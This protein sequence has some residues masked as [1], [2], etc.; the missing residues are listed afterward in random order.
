VNDLFGVEMGMSADAS[1]LVVGA[2]GYDNNVGAFW[3]F[4]RNATGY[5]EEVQS[6]IQPATTDASPFIASSVAMS[7]DGSTVAIGILDEE[8]T[9]VVGHGAVAMYTRDSG[10]GQWSLLQPLLFGDTYDVQTRNVGKS[11]GISISGDVVVSAGGNLVVADGSKIMT[12]IRGSDGLFTNVGVDVEHPPSEA[13]AY[14]A[15]VLSCDAR[16][17]FVTASDGGYFYTRAQGDTTVWTLRT[18]TPI[19]STLQGTTTHTSAMACDGRITAT[20][21]NTDSYANIIAD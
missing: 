20:Q 21:S 4:E 14:D 6:T 7:A 5:Y 16:T 13:T 1:I 17:L 12:W 8:N 10:T 2:P 18:T 11:L 15:M 3:A 19:D 9:P